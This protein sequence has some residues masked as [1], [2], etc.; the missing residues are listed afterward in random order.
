[1]W[2]AGMKLGWFM[3]FWLYLGIDVTLRNSYHFW[4][5]LFFKFT[6]SVVIIFFSCPVLQGIYQS[7]CGQIMCWILSKEGSNEIQKNIFPS[8]CSFSLLRISVV[9]FAPNRQQNSTDM[10]CLVCGIF[11]L[12]K[13]LSV[14]SPIGKQFGSFS[15]SV[16]LYSLCWLD[17]SQALRL[18]N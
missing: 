15:L 10:S 13:T 16:N 18:I 14:I 4:M 5:S 7:G 8:L 17:D 12:S 11:F 6:K 1:M 9:Q 2:K 3:L